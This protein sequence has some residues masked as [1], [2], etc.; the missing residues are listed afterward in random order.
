MPMREPRIDL[1]RVECCLRELQRA[2]PR[3]NATVASRRDSLSDEVVAN[4]LLGYG[5][6]NRMLEVDPFRRGQ[7]SHLLELN[8]IVLCGTSPEERRR[9]HRHIEATE[10]HFYEVVGGGIR[11]I[12]E[13]Y[14]RNRSDDPCRQA[15]GVYVHALSE[16]QLFIEGN[17]RTGSLIISFMLVR[18]GKPPFVV[19][20]DNAKGYFDPSTLIRATRKHTLLALWQLP[21]MKKTFAAFLRDHVDKRALAKAPVAAAE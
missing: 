12:M 11:E 2:F 13:W 19:S 17:H 6:V 9:F 8:T 1:D 16:P 14:D 4:L 7:H 5:Y 18:A 10:A 15:A 3:I 20:P 21:K